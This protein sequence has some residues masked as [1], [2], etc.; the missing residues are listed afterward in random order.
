MVFYAYDIRGVYGKEIDEHFAF[1]LA[2]A[3]YLTIG[4]ER[5]KFAIGKDVRVHS[6]S[7][8]KA[9]YDALSKTDSEI[10][11]IDTVPTPLLYFVIAHRDLDGG[12]MI[13]ASHNPPEWNGFKLCRDKAY[14]IAQG[15]GMEKLKE[16]FFSKVKPAERT[17]RTIYFKDKAIK[18]YVNYVSDRVGLKREIKVAIDIGNGACFELAPIVMK[19]IGAKIR[20]INE[21]PN[22]LFPNRPPEPKE[23]NL[24][25]LK[26]VMKSERLDFGVAYDGDGDRAVFVDDLGRVIPGDVITAIFAKHFLKKRKGKIVVE[27][28]FSKAIEEYIRSLGGEIVESRVGHAYIMDLVIKESALLGGEVSSHF[29]FLDIYG[30]DDAIYATAKMA[31]LLSEEGV[32]LSELV[33]E[34][35]RLPN[36]PVFVIDVPDDEKFKI[37]DEV[38]SDFE[39]LGFKIS[40]I[41]GVKAFS[42]KGWVLVRASN[43]MPQIKFKAE[44]NSI[45]EL[46][47]LIKLT[48]EL[49]G[50]AKNR[51]ERKV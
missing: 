7:L 16:I 14:I 42:R 31:E 20:L 25:L 23:E 22:G 35:P 4:K 36:S 45:E 15:M 3:F 24:S 6:N 27:V 21:E 19:T 1:R 39:K 49:I 41:D 9:F 50:K 5:P 46:D 28:N 47:E 30:L 2:Q 8:E 32:R 17:G 37:V 18:E 38:A 34:V 48:R 43:T 33:N 29:Y 44:G 13:T 51:V 11:R 40:R 26:G 10:Y 12:V